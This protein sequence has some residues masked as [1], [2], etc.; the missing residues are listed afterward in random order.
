MLVNNQVRMEGFIVY[1]YADR[2]AEARAEIS[3]WVK[4]GKMKPWL[5]VYEGLEKAPQAFVDL[6]AGV[7][8]GTTVVR[9]A[10]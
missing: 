9:I 1:S 2:Y 10:D 8:S 5:T 3:Q 4:E 7:T 6:L